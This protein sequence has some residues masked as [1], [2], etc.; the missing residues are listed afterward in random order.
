MKDSR[1][2]DRALGGALAVV[3]ALLVLTALRRDPGA[4]LFQ[5]GMDGAVVAIVVGTILAMVHG[6]RYRTALALM[7]P[8]LAAQTLVLRAVGY[9]VVPGAGLELAL[10][11]ALGLVFGARGDATVAARAP[12]PIDASTQPFEPAPSA[13][14]RS[15]AR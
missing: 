7:A 1:T 5:A 13:P 11:G 9:P 15:A 4:L 10:V 3:G 14:E 2:E 8:I 12:A 6:L